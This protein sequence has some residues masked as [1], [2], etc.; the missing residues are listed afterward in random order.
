MLNQSAHLGHGRGGGVG[1]KRG[2][3]LVTIGDS[4]IISL[5]AELR[6]RKLVKLAPPLTVGQLGDTGTYHVLYTCPCICIIHTSMIMY[7]YA[8]RCAYV[9]LLPIVN[10]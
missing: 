8:C 6:L 7:V 4:N 9:A 3:Y 2:C 10:L 5:A 1:D